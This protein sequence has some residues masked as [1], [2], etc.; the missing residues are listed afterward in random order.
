MTHAVGARKPNAWGLHDML[1][2]VWEGV[3]DYYNDKL[4][5]DPAAP[6]R[7]VTHVLKGG[8]FLSDVKNAVY[9]THAGGPG[10]GFD[11]GFRIVRDVPA[12]GR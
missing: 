7:G 12:Q 2:N 4:F 3:S 10:D 5:A 11:I 8:G 9:S 6:R 1:G